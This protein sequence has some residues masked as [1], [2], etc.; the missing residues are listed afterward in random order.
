[1]TGYQTAAAILGIC[2]ALLFVIYACARRDDAKKKRAASDFQKFSGL[3][4]EPSSKPDFISRAVSGIFKAH[5][6]LNSILAVIIVAVVLVDAIFD[7]V[8]RLIVLSTICA[9]LLIILFWVVRSKRK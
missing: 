9:M 7:R 2:L 5:T 6:V 1:M 3:E 8:T 4:P